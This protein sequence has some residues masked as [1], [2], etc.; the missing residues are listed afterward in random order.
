[1]SKI[2]FLSG[3][4]LLAILSCQTAESTENEESIE[5][6]ISLE[7]YIVGEWENV[8]LEVVVNSHNN[9]DSSFSILVP[10]GSWEEKLGIKPIQ[11]HY[12]SNNTYQSVYRS[13]ND[14]IVQTTR[15]IWNVF[16]DTLMLI[17]SDAT[18]EYSVRLRDSLGEFRAIL[19]WDGDGKIDDTYKGIQVKKLE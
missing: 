3:Y 17:E 4:L 2:W 1:M 10:K 7:D 14:S 11:T 19:D 16:G 9:T 8:S 6:T 18:Y 5:S 12:D 13:L 15:G